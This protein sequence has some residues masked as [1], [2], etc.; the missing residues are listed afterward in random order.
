MLL[1]L[2]GCDEVFDLE[3]VPERDLP[4]DLVAYYP[5]DDLEGGTTLVDLRGGASGACL[6]GQCPTKVAGRSKGALLFDGQTQMITVPTGQMLATQ[7]S[8]TVAAWLRL[9]RAP[10]THPYGCPV[11]KLLGGGGDNS[12]QFCFYGGQWYLYV[13][14]LASGEAVLGPVGDFGK[15]HHFAGTWNMASNEA[16]LFVDGVNTGPA[17]VHVVDFDAGPIFIGGDIDFGAPIAWFPG[18]IDD[19]RIYNRDLDEVEVF[20]LAHGR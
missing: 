18:A 2:V 1:L 3:P 7:S 16:R 8:F 20:D 9:D 12:W 10:T 5:M 15:W 17:I 19:V 14:S 11:N 6:A 4:P 13:Y